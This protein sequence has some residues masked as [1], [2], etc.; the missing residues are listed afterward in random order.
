[1][2]DGVLNQNP[3]PR[4]T[5]ED[6]WEVIL[7]NQFHDILPG[8][9]IKEVYED[10][11]KEYEA[12]GETGRKLVDHALSNVLEG[13]SAHKDNL[14]VFNPN[15]FYG[16]GAVSF[17]APEYMENL[18]VM[19]GEILFPAQKAGDGSWLF[20][21]S[22][23]PSK[24]YK[25]Y[26]LREGSCDTG[27]RADERH[28]E[29]EFIC[30]TLHENGQI[31]SIYDKQNEREVLKEN[32]HANVLM[33]YEDRPHNYD[34]WDVN[35]YYVEKSWE[36]TDVSSME[37]VENGPVRA[38]ICVK[39]R[40]LDSIIEQYISLLYN[41]PEI[42]IR[43]EIDWKENHIF[44]KSILP[45]DIHTDEATF[46][47]Q[48]GNVKRKTHYNTMWDYAKFEVCMHKWIDVSEDDYGV[49]MINDCKYGCHV[50]DGEIGISM[51]KSAT[52][53]NPDADKEHHSFV[54]SIY[55]HKGD[56]KT[57]GTIQKAY[58]MNNPMTALVKEKDG[59]QLP[60]AFSLVQADADNVVIEVVKQSQKGNELIL[61][62]YETN[63]RRTIGNMTF[64]MDIQRI[65]ECNM[66]EEEE[67]EVTYQDRT[68]SFT[69]HPYE[70]KTWKVTFL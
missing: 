20:C 21:A 48:Y 63:N 24:G 40:Y 28:L 43:N 30:V 5:I 66:L 12:I 42:I 67:A 31:S 32:R 4:E 51:L 27:L 1:M 29:N 19:D 37:L 15:S 50:H 49:S 68:A 65:M 38:T 10:S 25:T 69:I 41:S 11:K 58:T 2:L 70:I 34:A 8:S 52:Y 44:L 16:E 9:S 17:L 47:I 60:G 45:V 7:R 53:P 59:G 39:R 26:E 6:A 62:F 61:R 3:Y 54:F 33:T 13:V 18:A 55:P 36:I 22:Q 56:W 57:A 23:V 46:E 35:N 14:V 64:G